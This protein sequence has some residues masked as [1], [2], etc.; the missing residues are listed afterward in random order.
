MKRKVIPSATADT[1]PAW[2]LFSKSHQI[3]KTIKRRGFFSWLRRRWHKCLY[4]EFWFLAI[5]RKKPDNFWEDSSGFVLLL[6][7]PGHFYADPCLFESNS[8]NYIFFEDFDLKAQKGAIACVEIESATKHTYPTIVL[9]QPY[10]LSYPFLFEWRGDVYL[11]P[12]SSANRTIELYR[13]VHFPCRWELVKVLMKDVTAT[14]ATLFKHNG[15]FW[16]FT[17]SADDVN[18]DLFLFAADSPLGPWLPH[19]KNPIVSDPSRSRPA[20]AL[21]FNAGHLLR[22]SQDC[23]TDYGRAICLNSVTVLSEHDYSE[24]L[25][26]RIDP[27]CLYGDVRTHTLSHN[28]D[29]EVRDGSWRVPKIFPG[30]SA[31][32]RRSS[33]HCPPPEIV[34]KPHLE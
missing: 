31:C 16:M 24:V 34:L 12:E 28:D 9:E 27:G 8:A 20:G 26:A 33:I 14:D 7:P 21:F 4:D 25:L 11:I 15:R 30:N 13:A 32:R 18:E 29:W 1:S 10:H 5:R 19:P 17:G 3:I 2:T 6:P 22:P 23:S